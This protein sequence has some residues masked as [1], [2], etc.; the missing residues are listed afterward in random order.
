M[1]RAPTTQESQPPAPSE[2]REA[3]L[4]LQGVGMRFGE[5][6][7]LKDVDLEV[8]RG[9]I[10]GIAGPNGSGK[11]TLFNAVAG[12]YRPT[13]RILLEGANIVGLGPDRVCRKGIARTFQ[14]PQVFGSMTAEDN[15]RVGAHFGRAIRGGMKEAINDA[16]ATVGLEDKR[17]VVAEHLNLLGRKLLMLAAALA[18]DPFL[19]L[20]D[21]PMGGLTPAEIHEFGTLITR[22]NRESGM[23]VIVIEHKVRKLVE[24]S[25]RLMILYNGE[26]VALG[27]PDEVVNDP[28]VIDLYLGGSFHAAC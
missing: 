22:L 5:I 8:Y 25:D 17:S 4:Q 15:I 27:L 19:L 11:S 23:T 7:A 9:E 2:T 12:V 26:L 3:V 10:L 14:I 20:L 28:R 1:T 18:T 24:L 6:T 16:V 13:G 21:E